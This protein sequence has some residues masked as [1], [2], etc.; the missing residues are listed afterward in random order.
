MN[1][2]QNLPPIFSP[3]LFAFNNAPQLPYLTV[4]SGLSVPE[5]ARAAQQRGAEGTLKDNLPLSE[6]RHS[7]R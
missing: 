5:T 1:G 4:T 3:H 6:E 2:M 7:A